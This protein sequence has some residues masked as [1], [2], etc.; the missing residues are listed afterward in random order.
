MQPTLTPSVDFEK[1]GFFP[2]SNRILTS[3]DHH[4]VLKY[5]NDSLLSPRFSIPRKLARLSLDPVQSANE[6][7][8]KSSDQ[9]SNEKEGRIWR[10][11]GQS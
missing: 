10:K 8:T 7:K 1:C 9:G 11:L 6:Q 3:E 5:A 4:Q 2:I